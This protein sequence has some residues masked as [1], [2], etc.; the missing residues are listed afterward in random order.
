[1]ALAESDHVPIR[2]ELDGRG[3]AESRKK[4]GVKGK[5]GNELEWREG[6]RFDNDSEEKL[7]KVQVEDRG[8]DSFIQRSE[9]MA[10]EGDI[11]GSVDFLSGF[12]IR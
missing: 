8:L 6:L 7:K 1:M 2:V 3:W 5:M 11:A 9:D 4:I 12:C 10:R